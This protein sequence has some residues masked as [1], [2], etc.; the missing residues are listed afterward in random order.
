MWRE[1]VAAKSRYD[2]LSKEERRTAEP[3]KQKRLKL[4]DT[5]IEAAQEVFRDSPD[6]VLCVRDEWS[7]GFGSMDKY[8][9]HRGAAMDRA[10]WLQA[11]NGG[12]YGYHRVTRG[13]GFI[14]NLS[15]S[16]L[17]GIQPEPMRKICEG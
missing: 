15:A 7:G 17:G 4:E 11:Y 12:S 10:F 6:G 5:T 3:P 9:G 2:G 14:P 1:Y 8:A 16:I 13:S